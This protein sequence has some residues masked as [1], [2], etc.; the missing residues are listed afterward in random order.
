MKSL[1][2]Y[3]NFQKIINVI[4]LLKILIYKDNPDGYEYCH[5]SVDLTYDSFMVNN[6]NIYILIFILYH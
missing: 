5:T 3:E 1:N 2:F 6:N 4:I